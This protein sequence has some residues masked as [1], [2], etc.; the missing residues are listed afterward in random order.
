MDSYW[1]KF[2]YYFHVITF[3]FCFCSVRIS[4]YGGRYKKCYGLANRVG[5]STPTPTYTRPASGI[6]SKH[7]TLQATVSKNTNAVINYV[8]VNFY[9][10]V[11]NVLSK[12][13]VFWSKFIF[14]CQNLRLWG[15]NL[16]F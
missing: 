15:Q 1:S 10:Y 16:R 5:G 2:I 14:L 7:Y 9:L 3:L 12:F 6:Y 13:K 11:C 4:D 8:R